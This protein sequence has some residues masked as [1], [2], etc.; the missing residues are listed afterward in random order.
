MLSRESIRHAFRFCLVG[1]LVFLVDLSMLWLWSHFTPPL[2]AVSVA[3]LIAVTVHFCFNKWWVFQNRSSAYS[4][5][6]LKYL[7]TVFCCWLCTVAV[8]SV[9]LRWLTTNIYLAKLLAIP[10]TTLL[11]FVLMKL[12]VF[13]EKL[14]G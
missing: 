5:Q 7:L 4:A 1:G 11:G 9:A 14:P 8:F 3:Y 10:P 12:F 6:L 2:V 13:R